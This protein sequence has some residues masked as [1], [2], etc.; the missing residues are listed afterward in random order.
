M[1]YILLFILLLPINCFA[2]SYTK[3]NNNTYK[4]KITI[5]ETINKTALQNDIKELEQK[6]ISCEN[7]IIPIPDNIDDRIIT[8]I[9]QRNEFTIGEKLMF[10]EELKEKLELLDNLK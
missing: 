7:E 6:I 3:I 9:N 10:K 5:I 8:L 2:Q 1:R 4:K